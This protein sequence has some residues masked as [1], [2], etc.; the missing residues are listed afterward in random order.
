MTMYQ[1]AL[2]HCLP[3]LYL[4]E[5]F[6][7]DKGPMYSG[8]FFGGRFGD[9]PAFIRK[10]NIYWDTRT[11]EEKKFTKDK[12]Q[13]YQEKENHIGSVFSDTKFVISDKLIRLPLNWAL[14]R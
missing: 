11:D 5:T 3:L 2:I 8:I 9:N 14:S 4:N 1:K 7:H 10:N 13:E 12:L 6:F